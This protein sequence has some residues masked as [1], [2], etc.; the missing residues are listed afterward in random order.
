MSKPT[1]TIIGTKA[2]KAVLDGVNAIYKPVSLTF[3]PQGRNVLL[4]RT[5]NRGGRITNDGYTVAECQE[6][7]DVFARLAAATFKESCK[8]TNERVGDGTTGTA[9]I[10]GKLFN[11]VFSLLSENNSEYTAK[12]SGE[13]GVMTLRN[14]ILESATKVK[15]EIKKIASKIETIE[16]LE[17]IAIVSVEDIEL[18][19][20]IAKMAWDVGVDGFIDT[21]EGYKGEI[22]TEVIRGM[23]FPAKVAN[24]VFVNIPARFEMVAQD[25]P[26]LLTNYALDN[27][28]DIGQAFQELNKF[29]SKLIVIAPSFSDNVLT[30][31]VTAIKNGFFIYPVL[32]PSLRTEQFEDV[33][34]YCGATFIDKNKGRRLKN[35]K[36][37][38][39]GFL[40]KLIVKGT[41][42]RE[43]AV[44]TG[45]KGSQ[46]I[47]TVEKTQDGFKTNTPVQERI[48]TL[49]AQLKETQQEQF[50]KLLER[51]IASMGSAVGV[52]RVGDST[53]ASS[54]YRKLKIEDAVYACK[55]ALRGGYVRGGGLCLKEIAES[56]PEDDI[57]K[58]ALLAP[59]EQI[60]SS[61]E[62]GVE[63]G[64]DII[65]PAEAIYYAVEHATSVVAALAT[66]EAMTVEKEENMIGDGEFAI[67]RALNELVINDKIYKGQMG[68]NERE[69]ER[70]R[71]GGLTV[72]EKISLD[73]G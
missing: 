3:G 16:Q 35:I 63:I 47:G 39:L 61:V 13:A 72:E 45:G 42:S 59:Y 33:A 67:S 50:K 9:I 55:A 25:C 41:E 36:P 24:Q 26:V 28:S 46:G 68:E 11:D 64:S 20:I 1:Q 2:R 21:V 71:M 18:G 38:D 37:V 48:E 22:E 17:K 51:R 30:G 4:Y 5:Y 32:A 19:K 66:V 53:Q 43:E 15:D 27:G 60:Q 10:G 58:S 29:T 69:Q 70:D 44:A 62:G 49:K 73:N 34:T 40:E 52:I 54:L 57:L 23:R 14:K 7:E 56:L 31:M 6:P 8:R 12:K 65:D